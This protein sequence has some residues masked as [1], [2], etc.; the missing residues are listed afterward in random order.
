MF[1][2]AG[3]LFLARAGNEGGKSI[4][5]IFKL[6]ADASG[7]EARVTAPFCSQ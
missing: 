7:K 5:E 1:Q 3:G 4:V 6:K 2:H